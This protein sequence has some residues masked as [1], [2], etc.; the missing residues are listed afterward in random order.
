MVHIPVLCEGVRAFLLADLIR[1]LE[2]LNLAHSMLSSCLSQCPQA[3]VIDQIFLLLLHL[4][5][6]FLKDLFLDFSFTLCIPLPQAICLPILLCSFTQ[7]YIAFS[8]IKYNLT[9]TKAHYQYTRSSI[10]LFFC[11]SPCCHSLDRK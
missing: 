5:L 8:S 3:A 10:H 9:L 4:S 2:S 7:I 6:T 11:Q 1:A